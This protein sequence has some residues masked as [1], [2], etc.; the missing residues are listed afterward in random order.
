MMPVICFTLLALCA[1]TKTA[2]HKAST[3]SQAIR[4][5]VFS[6]EYL[7]GCLARRAVC[8]TLLQNSRV[9]AWQVPHPAP[10]DEAVR[11]CPTFASRWLTWV[12]FFS[13][14][15]NIA[16]PAKIIGCRSGKVNTEN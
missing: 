1:H 6:A 4:F 11:R 8:P 3:E 12:G 13:N 15:E 16:H 9:F 10:Q 7:C 5:I 2:E 14:L